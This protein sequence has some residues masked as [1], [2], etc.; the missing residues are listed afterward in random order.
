MKTPLV[1]VLMPVYNCELYIESAVNSILSQTYS[2]FEFFIIDD[3]STDNTINILNNFKDPRIRLIKKTKNSGY[4]K[5][6]NDALSLVKGKYIARMDG[7]D[8][9]LPERFEK[10]IAVLENNKNV[11]VCGTNFK[12][13]GT[14]TIIKN[15]EKDE[16]IKL[17]L[18]KESCIGHP[19]VIIRAKV[20]QQNHINYN[21]SMEPAEDYDL[22]VR[23]VKY[24]D[25]F[26]IQEPLFLYRIHENQVSSLRKEKQRNSA[27]KSRL[28]MLRYLE[29]PF[30]PLEE[31]S[32]IKSFS[33]DQRLTFTE[34]C[35][36]LKLIEKALKANT[37]MFPI[38]EFK[39]TLLTFQYNAISQFFKGNKNYKP[40]MI[41]Q[42]LYIKNLTG[43]SMSYKTVLKLLFKSIIFKKAQ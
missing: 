24:G 5:N 7:D 17:H 34:L 13:L 28:N 11:I 35:A 22:W 33:F 29:E 31:K 8:I 19:T 16:E 42:Y 27:S 23:L 4:T 9:S 30:T 39:N 41:W 36:F 6:L 2:N 14:E 26:N 21:S 18:V 20:M 15:P 1:S 40:E 32:Y 12:L 43:F 38:N 3:A 25:F 10:Q 37:K